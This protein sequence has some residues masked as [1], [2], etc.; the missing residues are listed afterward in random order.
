[1]STAYKATALKAAEDMPERNTLAEYAK[2]VIDQLT[3]AHPEIA[4]GV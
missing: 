4:W 1:M 3:A 2:F